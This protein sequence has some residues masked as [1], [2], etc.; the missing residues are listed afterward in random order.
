M[1]DRARQRWWDPSATTL[2]R[3]ALIP[4]DATTES[5]EPF[6][7]LPDDELVDSIVSNRAGDRPVLYGHYWRSGSTPS[8]DNARAACLD[9]SI[10]GGGHLVAYRWT[11]ESDL[12][13]A[14]LVAVR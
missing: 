11:G 1:R 2:A 6:P 12:T 4:G 14:N 3:A 9:W 10:A 7:P 8:I 13:D 5:G